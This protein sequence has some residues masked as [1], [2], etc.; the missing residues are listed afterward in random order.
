MILS[1]SD[2]PVLRTAFMQI[3][4]HHHQ[5]AL[6]GHP[7]NVREKQHALCNQLKLT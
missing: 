2:A 7:R 3:H 4:H 6:Q 1:L 5:T